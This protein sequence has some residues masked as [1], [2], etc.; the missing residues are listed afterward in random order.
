V[1]YFGQLLEFLFLEHV[2][3][4]AIR[5]TVDASPV[6]GKWPSAVS[7]PNVVVVSIAQE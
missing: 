3:T 4:T 1:N 5:H 2:R 6:E 7:L